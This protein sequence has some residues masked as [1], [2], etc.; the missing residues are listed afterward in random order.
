MSLRVGA[1]RQIINASQYS[2]RQIKF[3]IVEMPSIP[4]TKGKIIPYTTQTEN[5]YMYDLSEIESVRKS[6]LYEEV[7]VEYAM[8]KVKGDDNIVLFYGMDR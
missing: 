8:Q 2:C 1:W 4:F 3:G 7:L 5:D 6:G